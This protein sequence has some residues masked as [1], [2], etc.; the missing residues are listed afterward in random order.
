MK[1]LIIIVAFFSLISCSSNNKNE[2][3]IRYINQ[4]EKNIL[5]LDQNS[6]Y[7]ILIDLANNL[8]VYFP[9]VEPY[10][11][12]AKRTKLNSDSLYKQIES[13]KKRIKSNKIDLNDLKKSKNK[14]T[15]SEKDKL[16]SSINS[17]EDS[18]INIIKDVDRNRKMKVKIQEH[19]DIEKNIYQASINIKRKNSLELYALLTLIELKIKEIESD[20]STYL[21]MQVDAHNYKFYSIDPIIIPE[22]TNVFLGDEFKANIFFGHID[23]FIIPRIV[24]EDQ[25]L[26]VKS[27]KAF[28]KKRIT[29]K[30][31][32]IVIEHGKIYTTRGYGGDTTNIPFTIEYR[33][34]K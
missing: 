25:E 22:R 32:G 8:T 26:E 4:I 15:R 5:F 18:L 20:V 12:R 17:Y 21:A 29:S 10:W 28:Y 9:K 6:G 30:D 31:T 13:V 2:V 24:V 3:Y 1:K 34:V 19:F 23:T 14:L 11:T 33:V 7:S 27:G 16:I